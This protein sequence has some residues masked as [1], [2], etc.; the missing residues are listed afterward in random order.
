MHRRTLLTACLTAP[1]A[2]HA[3]G[4]ATGPAAAQGLL[5]RLAGTTLGA[6]AF[7]QEVAIA[8][9]FA[10][11]SSRVLLA[12]STHPQ[13]R[14]FAQRMI[15]HHTML[16]NEMRALPEASTRLPAALDDRHTSLLITLRGQE[17]IDLL[18][19]YYIQQQIESHED[20]VTA[21]ETY[22]NGG[23]VPALKAFAQRHLPMIRDHLQR[24]RTLQAPER[25]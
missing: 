3:V 14:D 17:D 24:A 25:G 16:A 20:A 4:Q 7:V 22:A 10:I 13:I 5:E 1:L 12:R 6:N 23:D 19:R 21:Y 18:N 2:V 15:D 11:E 8:D 9:N